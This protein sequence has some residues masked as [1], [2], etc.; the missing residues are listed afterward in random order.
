M[1]APAR[2]R[3]DPGDE[4][5]ESRSRTS[6]LT[7][8]RPDAGDDPHHGVCL[9]ED[10]QGSGERGTAARAWVNG[11]TT[12]WGREK[13]L[14]R[15]SRDVAPWRPDGQ[16]YRP[17]APC[18]AWRWKPTGYSAMTDVRCRGGRR[19]GKPSATAGSRAGPATGQHVGSHM[20][21]GGR[22]SGS[23]SFRVNAIGSKC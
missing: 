18:S 9:E 12:H 1:K 16:H 21:Q 4:E 5:E 8:G 17:L 19:P 10:E 7:A 13:R 20:R 3:Q 23:S 15:R 2:T 6:S 11:R 22:G 14:V